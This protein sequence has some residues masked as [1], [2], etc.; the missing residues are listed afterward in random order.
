MCVPVRAGALVCKWEVELQGAKM[1]SL[2]VSITEAHAAF[3]VGGG[4]ICQHN[5][6]RCGTSGDW[7]NRT[8]FVYGG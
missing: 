5:P 1:F 3:S 2:V 7:G 6:Y 4:M 8:V